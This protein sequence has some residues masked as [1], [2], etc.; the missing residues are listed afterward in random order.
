MIRWKESAMES[1]RTVAQHCTGNAAGF[2]SGGRMSD[3]LF[4]AAGAATT[5]TPLDTLPCC[6]GRIEGIDQ[7]K[8]AMKRSSTI[9]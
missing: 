5:V 1:N 8:S 9:P 4:P 7:L 2:D 6:D 3:R